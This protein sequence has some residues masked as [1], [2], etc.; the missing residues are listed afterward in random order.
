MRQIT[1]NVNLVSF[2]GL[3][4]GACRAYLSGK[5]PG[6]MENTKAG[7]CKIRVCCSENK[8]KSCA[9]CVDF[10][11]VNDC[12]KFNNAISKIFAFVF[13]SNRKACIQQ[14]R[15]K[16]LKGHAEIMSHDIKRHTLPL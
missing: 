10:K 11:D 2:C 16:G 8:L 13:R 7:W 12:K 1:N 14:I 15:D 9:D 6:C 5:C 3:Y 4:C